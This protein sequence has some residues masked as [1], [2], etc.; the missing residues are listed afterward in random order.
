[1]T[2]MGFVYSDSLTEKARDLARKDRNRADLV[3]EMKHQNRTKSYNVGQHIFGTLLVSIT[4]G[5]YLH[6]QCKIQASS[7]LLLQSRYLSIHLSPL[8][9]SMLIY[10]LRS[11]DIPRTDNV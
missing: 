7:L 6:T 3:N 8:A 5:K 2:S 10:L 11:V 9:T 4:N 1:M